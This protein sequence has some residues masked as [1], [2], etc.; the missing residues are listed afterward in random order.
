MT[1][2]VVCPDARQPYGGVQKLYDH[3]D[4][5]N[6]HG[7]PAA[8]LHW[9]APYRAS[10]FANATSIVYSGVTLRRGDLL[11]VPESFGDGLATYA[12]GVPRVSVVQN[13][14]DMFE[15]VADHNC[16][17]Y[18]TTPD[19]CGVMVISENDR[20]L[21]SGFFSNIDLDIRRVHYGFDPAVFY[22][23]ERPRGRVLSYMPR[24]RPAEAE[25]LLKLVDSALAGWELIRIEGM[26][27]SEVADAY[28]R[29]AMFLSFS[30]HEGFGMP[31]VEALACGCHVM[32]FDGFGGREY[33]DPRFTTRVED[34]DILAFGKALTE[35]LGNYE[36]STET[37]RRSEDASAFAL[38]TYSLTREASEVSAFYEDMTE[39]ASK[40]WNLPEAATIFDLPPLPPSRWRKAAEH[41]GKAVWTWSTPTRVVRGVFRGVRD[42]F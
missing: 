34:G 17:P 31:P 41:L 36:G 19:L 20:A 16:H 27:Q 4:I 21:V 13:G 8:I 40:R 14:F 28:R 15:R 12:P 24:K 32:G 11:A 25:M 22:N 18:G 2:Y 10:W 39:L 30:D 33:F 6:R 3:V 35:W 5:L 38:E 37:A 26:S 9:K 7:I 23:S 42:R 29:S 1:V